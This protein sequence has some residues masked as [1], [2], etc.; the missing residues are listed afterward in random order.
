MPAK[1]F[2]E[3]C[4]PSRWGLRLGRAQRHMHVRAHHW[5]MQA[6]C[7]TA[8]SLRA[9]PWTIL[10]LGMPVSRKCASAAARD[11]RLGTHAPLAASDLG[12][13]HSPSLSIH[14]ETGSKA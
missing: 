2:P 8:S 5:V 3:L 12:T 11:A 14:Q 7:A 10:G 4:S 13:H 6:L 1:P 9:S